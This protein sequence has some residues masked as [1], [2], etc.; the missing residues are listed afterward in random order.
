MNLTMSYVFKTY[1][2]FL[3]EK[4]A[5]SICS[6][7]EEG[8]VVESDPGFGFMSKIFVA[9]FPHLILCE[10]NEFFRKRLQ[11]CSCSLFDA[12]CRPMIGMRT[13]DLEKNLELF[14]FP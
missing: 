3:S 4:I 13:V 5:F 7:M 11:V 8:F 14:S 2:L 9:E 6:R 10:K 12:V 1:T